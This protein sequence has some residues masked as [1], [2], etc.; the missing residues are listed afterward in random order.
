M[1]NLFQIIGDI[2]QLLHIVLSLEIPEFTCCNSWCN[3]ADLD[4]P[5]IS[6]TARPTSR[7]IRIM[8]T[9]KAN[10]ATKR[11]AVT[12]NTGHST[13]SSDGRKMKIIYSCSF[14]IKSMPRE[15]SINKQQ[16]IFLTAASNLA[17]G[18]GWNQQLISSSGFV[19]HFFRISSQPHLSCWLFS[20]VRNQ[21]SLDFINQQTSSSKNSLIIKV[22]N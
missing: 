13:W 3:L 6:D 2:N 4:K 21:S 15:N 10:M 5:W 1:G 18:Q 9:K 14:I 7:F 20:K 19:K 22:K 11:W 12:G 16:N 8:D 17:A